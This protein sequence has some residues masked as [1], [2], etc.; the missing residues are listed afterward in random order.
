MKVDKMFHIRLTECEVQTAILNYLTA[1]KIIDK[2]Y[3]EHPLGNSWCIDTVDD[4]FAL[5]VNGS[6]ECSAEDPL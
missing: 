5:V 6:V 3:L 1:S 4:E 2:S